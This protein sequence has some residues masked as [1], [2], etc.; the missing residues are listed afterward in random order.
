MSLWRADVMC[1]MPFLYQEM[2]GAGVPHVAQVIRTDCPLLILLSSGVGL[3]AMVM[4]S[5]TLGLVIIV[6][7]II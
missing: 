7:V 4:E 5:C 2:D 1:R 6:S 3:L